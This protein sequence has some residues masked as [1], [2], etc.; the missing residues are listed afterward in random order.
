LTQAFAT[1]MTT[2]LCNKRERENKPLENMQHHTCVQQTIQF[3]SKIFGKYET[4]NLC[5]KQNLTP[6][7]HK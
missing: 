2:N 1:D 7:Q 5:Y 4:P 6:L 3:N